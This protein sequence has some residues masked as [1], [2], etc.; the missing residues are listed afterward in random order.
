MHILKVILN[1]VGETIVFRFNNLSSA[2][3]AR[4]ELEKLIFYKEGDS[5]EPVQINDDFGMSVRIPAYS[6][7]L[8]M[9]ID[10]EKTIEGDASCQ[11][12][13]QKIGSRAL[14]KMKASSPI[15]TPLEAAFPPI[16]RRM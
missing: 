12:T 16:G 11:F 1:G 10:F 7:V 13:T 9:Q 6:V 2:N 8:V 3:S 15:I 4:F 5:P 14:E